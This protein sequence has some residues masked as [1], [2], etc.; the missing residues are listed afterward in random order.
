MHKHQN[1]PRNQESAREALGWCLGDI[2]T[3][4]FAPFD[5]PLLEIST[6]RFS[7]HRCRE[8]ESSVRHC[9]TIT[10]F[11]NWQKPPPT[12]LSFPRG[13]SLVIYRKTVWSKRKRDQVLT[14]AQ[15]LFKFLHCTSFGRDSFGRHHFVVRLDKHWL[16]LWLLWYFSLFVSPLLLTNIINRNTPQPTYSLLEYVH[17]LKYRLRD[18]SNLLI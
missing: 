4:R 18:D 11:R 7:K 2:R 13:V 12:E 1:N 8:Q 10:S 14:R 6:S 3:I 9:R 16:I 15:T 17:S 5:G